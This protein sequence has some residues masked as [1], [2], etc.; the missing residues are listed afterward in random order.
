[1]PVRARERDEVYFFGSYSHLYNKSC[2]TFIVLSLLYAQQLLDYE[3]K[4]VNLG[5]NIDVTN[6]LVYY[7]DGIHQLKDAKYDI[8]K[9]DEI[10][11]VLDIS[12]LY[13]NRHYC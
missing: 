3:I 6:F 2:E 9:Y 1:M 11:N 7:I 4:H 13:N 10:S 12:V 5:D 8:K